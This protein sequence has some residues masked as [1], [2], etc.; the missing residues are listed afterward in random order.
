MRSPSVP[1]T[2]LDRVENAPSGLNGRLRISQFDAVAKF[3]EFVDHAARTLVLRSSVD[4]RAPFV[5]ADALVQNLPDEVTKPMSN[6]SNGLLVS[7]ARHITA[8]DDLEDAT[9]VLDRGV[10]C[11]IE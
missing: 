4:V 7:E 5:I 3:S 8:I 10:R 1:E 11:L 9:L 6:H 2:V